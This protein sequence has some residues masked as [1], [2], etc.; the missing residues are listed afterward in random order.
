MYSRRTSSPLDSGCLGAPQRPAIAQCTRVRAVRTAS[1]NLKE[2]ARGG[3]ESRRRHDRGSLTVL[4]G[5]AIVDRLPIVLSKSWFE[6]RSPKVTEILLRTELNARGGRCVLSTKICTCRE[7]E[8]WKS[9]R[10]ALSRQGEG[11]RRQ[12][13][14]NTPN[15]DETGLVVFRSHDGRNEPD[16]IS[17][18][19]MNLSKE[20]GR[21]IRKDREGSV[22]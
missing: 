14:T 8:W 3:G 7:C 15:A 21:G 5:R 18:L 19:A 17:F 12:E 9:V 2:V 13:G 11:A 10:L 6:K 20:H 22:E 16:F 1:R 4:H